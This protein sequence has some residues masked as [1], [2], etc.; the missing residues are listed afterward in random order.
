[1]SIFINHSLYVSYSSLSN[2]GSG[3]TGGM[4]FHIVN[5]S[6]DWRI[7]IEPAK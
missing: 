2:M 4:V 7:S 3:V 6:S 5:K 1:M